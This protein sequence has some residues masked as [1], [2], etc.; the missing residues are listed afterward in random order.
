MRSV[1]IILF[2]L[3]IWSVPGAAQ[4]Q[5]KGP[6]PSALCSQRPAGPLQSAAEPRDSLRTQIRSTYW[7]EGALIGGTLGAVGGAMLGHALCGLSEEAAKG[8]VGSSVLGGLLGAAVVAIPGAL[9]GGQV[10]KSS[11]ETEHPD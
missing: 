8:C 11:A 3:F 9:I 1:A 7:K 2:G 10:S 6:A 4:L 5:L